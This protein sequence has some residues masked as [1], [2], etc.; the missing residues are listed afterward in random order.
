MSDKCKDNIYKVCSD[1]SSIMIKECINGKYYDTH[2]LCP[3][4][5]KPVGWI[6]NLKFWIKKHKITIMSVILTFITAFILGAM[7]Y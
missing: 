6:V 2:L 7:I 1:G 5:P 3:E 4:L